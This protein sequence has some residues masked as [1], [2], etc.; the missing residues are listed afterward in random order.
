[1]SSGT[2][3][4]GPSTPPIRTDGIRPDFAASSTHARD[5]GSR[6]ARSFGFSRFRAVSI[7]RVKRSTTR[8]ATVDSRRK[9]GVACPAPFGANARRTFSD[10]SIGPRWASALT[11][12][13]WPGGR[14][15]R[16]ALKWRAPSRGRIAS[17][18]VSRGRA[19]WTEEERAREER[20]QAVRSE[21]DRA[22]GPEERLEETLQLSRLVAELQQGA[23]RN[24]SGR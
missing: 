5:T 19:E 1:M 20:A 3:R 16:R 14:V 6:S 13:T 17:L 24:V 15:R 8:S 7:H 12:S 2:N 9:N 23:T 10:P 21:E 18:D 4:S 22:K 11:D